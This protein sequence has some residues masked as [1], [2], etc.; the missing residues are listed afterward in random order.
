MKSI[1]KAFLALLATLLLV[2]GCSSASDSSGGAGDR[3]NS[4]A[5][6]EMA[7]GEGADADTDAS[8]TDVDVEADREVITTARATIVVADPAQS[9]T[10]IAEV[11]EN[12][13][14][15]VD[16]RS[17]STPNEQS[18]NSHASA[19]MTVR[20]PAEEL[21]GIL[22]SLEDLGEVREL[23][24]E[25][26]DVTQ[27]AQDLDARIEALETSTERLTQIMA[28]A[29]DSADLIAA[30]DALSERQAQLESLQAQRAHL[31]DQVAMSTLH[32]QL[33]ADAEPTI[34]AGGFLG[35]LQS[36]WHALV[37]FTSGLLV[38]AG[39]VLPWLVVLAIPG[40]ALVLALRR[41]RRRRR[42][43]AAAA[44]PSGEQQLTGDEPPAT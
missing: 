15:R 31:S 30:E 5:E 19:R 39:A 9:V 24:Q 22:V 2:T 7:T 6:P 41:R 28:D 35:G 37:S 40:T 20:V 27:E 14:G 26:E 25:A 34:E 21:D 42:A 44:A 38:A 32:L 3:H 10:E 1:T 16:E 43:Q 12:A 29:D 18:S 8:G 36:G 13:G 23:S 33:R 4:A 11:A 17:V